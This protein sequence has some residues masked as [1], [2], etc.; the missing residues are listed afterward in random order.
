[1]EIL[2][3]T[4]A[5]ARVNAGKTQEDVSKELKVSKAT[6]GAW[7]KG[8]QVPDINQAY[9]LCD[10]YKI[11]IDNIRWPSNPTLSRK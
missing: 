8:T 11:S 1:M 6:V 5:A 4:P 9:R 2:K 10:F 3:I 7:E